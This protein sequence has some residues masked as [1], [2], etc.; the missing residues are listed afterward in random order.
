MA[1]AHLLL[2]MYN[3]MLSRLGA[4]GW[5][6][7]KSPFE[8]VVGAVLTQNTSWSN[9]EKAIAVLRTHDLLEPE[10][11]EAVPEE[12]LAEYIRSS[13]Y[14]RLKASRLKNVL[15][16]FRDCC[17]FDFAF[18]KERFSPQDLRE[19]ILGIKGVGP[20]TADTILLYALELP[21]FVVDAYTFRIANR[22][23]LIP[24]ET[25]YDELQ[26][27]FAENLP[28]QVLLF[29]EYHALLVQIGKTFC[30]KKKSICENCPLH[31]FL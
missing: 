18:L 6:S 3:V 11:M 17:D 9:V 16:F 30:L 29:S 24:E 15:R 4:S 27:L 23:G 20:E 7:A 1:K 13:G 10:K 31:D 2:K 8:I 19:R 21:F 5:W 26:S 25:S 22:H 14:Y 28:Q 12:T